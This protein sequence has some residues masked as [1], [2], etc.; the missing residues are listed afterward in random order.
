MF[1]PRFPHK[2]RVWRARRDKFGEPMTDSEGDAVY[3][4][5]S[6]KTVVMLDNQPIFRSDGS[7]DTTTTD[8]LEF[9]YRT[10]GKS[11]RDTSDV[12]VSD[13]KLATPMFITPLEVGDRLEIID[14]ERTYWGEVVR[15]QTYNLGSNIWF[16][17]IRN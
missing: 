4:T 8:W 3:D 10:S 5:L 1:N 13:Y 11:T 2:L 12:V 16:N 6:L 7:F 17:E 9:G 15:K 14:Y